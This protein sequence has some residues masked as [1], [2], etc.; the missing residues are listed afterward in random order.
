MEAKIV[1]ALKYEDVIHFVEDG[2][3]YKMEIHIR[4]NDECKNKICDFAITVD[5]YELHR[6]RWK[7]VAGGCNHDYILK[8][9]PKYKCF[10]D[11]HNC[12]HYGY[13]TY[14][15]ENTLYYFK[16][17][18]FDEIE[19]QL[20]LKK[21]ELEQI[22]LVADDKVALQWKLNEMGIIDRWYQEALEAIEFLNNLTGCRWINPYTKDEE[23]FVMRP[24]TDKENELMERRFKEGYYSEESVTERR[25]IVLKDK[26]SKQIKKATEEFNESTKK[27]KEILDIKLSILNEEILLD[28]VIVYE[29]CKEVRFNWRGYGL[30]VRREDYD[31]YISKMKSECKFED[32]KFN[33]GRD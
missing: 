10:I 19:S 17:K 5:I 4:M 16:E 29:H 20:R 14:V 7:W 2:N 27:W 30:Q 9:A 25:I 26:I 24:L 32:W 6:S 31:R 1:S 28:N 3:N 13:F 23:R 12:N 18:K 8:Y 22:I 15:I 11:L 33:F 21:G